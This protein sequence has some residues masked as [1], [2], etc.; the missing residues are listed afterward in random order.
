MTE[1][2]HSK[3]S[4]LLNTISSKILPLTDF[5]PTVKSILAYSRCFHRTYGVSFG[6]AS[7]REI[8]EDLEEANFIDQ[9]KTVTYRRYVHVARMCLRCPRVLPH[10]QALNDLNEVRGQK[11]K[12]KLGLKHIFPKILVEADEDIAIL[13]IEG[14]WNA[15]NKKQSG[16]SS[17]SLNPNLF[18]QYA[19]KFIGSLNEFN[20]HVSDK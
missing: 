19:S 20:M 18:Y 5:V 12:V 9:V 11:T 14:I 6:E 7:V 4:K 13:W 2:G 17:S 10:I 3:H 1:V 16:S 15:L 8:A